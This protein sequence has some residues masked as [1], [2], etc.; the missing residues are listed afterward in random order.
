F[1]F[2]NSPRVAPVLVLGLALLVAAGVAA[3]GRRQVVGALAVGLLA[4]AG[5]A[6]PMRGGMLS[7]RVDRPEALPTYW[8]QVAAHLDAGD[9]DTRVLE[10]PGANF[11]AYR[12]G[13]AIEPITPLLTDRAYVSRE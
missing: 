8:E 12:W 4:V 7:A 9:H 5:L 11:A 13:N 6:A 2:R 1:A 10:L 3:L